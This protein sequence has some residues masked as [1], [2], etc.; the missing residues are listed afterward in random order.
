M[1]STGLTVKSLQVDC[2]RCRF[3]D[4]G[5]GVGNFSLTKIMKS[6][7]FVLLAVVAVASATVYFEETFDDGTYYHTPL[8]SPP[9]SPPL[10]RSQ[11]FLQ[12]TS[13][14]CVSVVTC[15]FLRQWFCHIREDLAFFFFTTPPPHPTNSGITLQIPHSTTRDPTLQKA[16]FA[17]FPLIQNPPPSPTS[18][19]PI[20]PLPFLRPEYCIS[21]YSFSNTQNPQKQT[22]KI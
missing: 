15:W 18:F 5:F 10:S 14:G 8:P 17:G 6:F 1:E 13:I 9:L 3:V 7:V 21:D 11:L 2:F 22:H 16:I 4:F 12:E 20:Q 19:P